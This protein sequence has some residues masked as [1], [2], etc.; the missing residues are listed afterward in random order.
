MPSKFPKI[1]LLIFFR[2]QTGPKH[3]I[4]FAV[5]FKILELSPCFIPG[6]LSLNWTRQIEFLQGEHF[7]KG[8]PSI[9]TR[10]Y[11]LLRIPCHPAMQKI[12]SEW[13]E[14]WALVNEERGGASLSTALKEGNTSALPPLR[15]PLETLS[16][17][18]PSPFRGGIVSRLRLGPQ[19]HRQQQRCVPCPAHFPIFNLDFFKKIPTDLKL[20]SPLRTHSSIVPFRAHCI[21]RVYL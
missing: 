8:G 7:C 14:L 21:E 17:L 16:T 9:V 1:R 13:K 20:A 18:L 15:K 2:V 11:F 12:Q 10:S 6:Q 19:A 3:S 4:N 5:H